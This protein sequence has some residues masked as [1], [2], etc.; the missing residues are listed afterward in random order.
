MSKRLRVASAVLD[1]QVVL[2]WLVFADVAVIPLAHAVQRGDLLWIATDAM[3]AELTRVL[4]GTL[5]AARQFDASAVSRCFL[6]W[7]ERRLQA[8]IA[9]PGLRCRDRDDQMFI[10]LAA[11]AGSS[12][13]FTRDR[14]LLALRRAA[15]AHG[16]TVLRPADWSPAAGATQ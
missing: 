4:S 2:D 16:V 11:A 7:S 1:T 14:A 13:L 5:A 6:R 15:H 9:A 12:W 8:P 10:D 3:H